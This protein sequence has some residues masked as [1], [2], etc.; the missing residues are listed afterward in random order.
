[1]HVVAFLLTTVPIDTALQQRK[2]GLAEE[3]LS[4]IDSTCDPATRNEKKSVG[5]L[6]TILPCGV[7]PVVRPR[8]LPLLMLTIVPFTP[9]KK[10][11]VDLLLSGRTPSA[12]A[13]PSLMLGGS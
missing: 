10:R 9:L 4:L 3:Q 1:M 5:S 11:M 12:V 8:V 13:P 2:K 6:W 7:L